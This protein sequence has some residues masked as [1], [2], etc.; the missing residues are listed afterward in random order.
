M[1]SLEGRTLMAATSGGEAMLFTHDQILYVEGTKGSDHVTV[2]LNSD[3][4]RIDV[5]VNGMTTT[6]EPDY[7]NGIMVEGRGGADHLEVIE[8]HGTLPLAVTLVGGAGKDMLVCGP[9]HVQI[10]GRLREMLI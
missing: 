3:F 6:F 5:T 4:R 2:V 9:G 7:L 10:Q 1:E 8:S